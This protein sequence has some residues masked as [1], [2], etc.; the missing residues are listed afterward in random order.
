M[1]AIKQTA[2]NTLHDGIKYLNLHTNK[3]C[4][5]IESSITLLHYSNLTP[6]HANEL[7]TSIFKAFNK[8][9]I[10]FFLN[11]Q[12][13]MMIIRP[14]KVFCKKHKSVGHSDVFPH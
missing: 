12:K 14:S 9:L 8:Y 10:Y 4:V 13:Y 6:T 1:L 2:S 3:F 7:V 11:G 5:N